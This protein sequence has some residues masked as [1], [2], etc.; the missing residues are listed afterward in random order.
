MIV[1]A[2]PSEVKRMER[3]YPDNH[4]HKL[5]IHKNQNQNFYYRKSTIIGFWKAL[6]HYKTQNIQDGGGINNSQ[7]KVFQDTGEMLQM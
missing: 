7:S 4:C 6:C 1:A 5:E 3:T 2:V